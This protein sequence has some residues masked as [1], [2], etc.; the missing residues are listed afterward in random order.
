MRLASSTFIVAHFF[1]EK[2][3]EKK[4]SIKKYFMGER[5]FFQKKKKVSINQIA[6]FLYCVWHSRCADCETRDTIE[7]KFNSRRILID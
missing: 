6:S 3:D 1:P 4:I 7:K 5:C 2:K